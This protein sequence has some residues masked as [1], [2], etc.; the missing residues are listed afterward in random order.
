MFAHVAQLLPE[1][2]SGEGVSKKNEGVMLT[3][4]MQDAFEILKK[5][6]LEAPVLAFADFENPFFWETDT[7]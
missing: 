4:E 5:A 2:L 3:R 1:H 7:S 6:C